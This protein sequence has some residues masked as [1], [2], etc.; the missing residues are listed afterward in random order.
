M[1]FATRYSSA[2]V[3]HP[4]AV[5]EQASSPEGRTVASRILALTAVAVDP[6]PVLGKILE[7]VVADAAEVGAA[8]PAV[9]LDVE[10][11]AGSAGVVPGIAAGRTGPV[12]LV[13]RVAVGL[14]GRTGLVDLVVLVV[15][16]P[17][18]PAGAVLAAADCIGLVG[19]VLEAVVLVVLAV[20]VLGAATVVCVG[21]FLGEMS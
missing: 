14:V 19:L 15:P 6:E 10:A 4:L 13:D 5:A 7:T 21:R 1:A 11:V 16:I 9:D 12:A 2:D 18:V 20:V 8:F 3:A 17:A